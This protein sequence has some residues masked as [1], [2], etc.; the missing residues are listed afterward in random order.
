MTWTHI[1]M[2]AYAIAGLVLLAAG[3]W[4]A[5]CLFRREWRTEAGDRPRRAAMA[6]AAAT[7]LALAWYCTFG[8]PAGDYPHLLEAYDRADPA[9]RPAMRA[10]VAEAARSPAF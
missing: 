1:W 8:P 2:G 4:M 6:L 9:V 5:E 7:I 3:V 10:V